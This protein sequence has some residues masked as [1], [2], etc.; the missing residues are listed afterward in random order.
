[1]GIM[2]FRVLVA[3]FFSNGLNQVAEEE[4]AGAELEAV[5]HTAASD[6]AKNVAAAFI[7]RNNAVGNDKCARS[8]DTRLNSSHHLTSRMPS[9]A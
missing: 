7:A 8:E 2:D 3:H 9:S 6:T 1:M 5:T 4:F